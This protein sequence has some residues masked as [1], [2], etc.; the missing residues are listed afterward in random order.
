MKRSPL[1]VRTVSAGL[2]ISLAFLTGCPSPNGN[3]SGTDTSGADGGTSAPAEPSGR[4]ST[5]KAE[6]VEAAKTLLEGLAPGTKYTL[7]PDG[8]MTEVIIPD[9]SKLTPENIAL[10]G[11]L[12]DLEKLQIMNYRDL[13]DDMV[14]KLVDLKNLKTLALTNSVIGDP[15]VEM[16]VKS[17]P[18]LTSLDLSS[19]TN[20]TNGVLKVISEMGQLEQLTLVQNRFNDLG[21]GRLAKLEKL[22]SWTFVATWRRGT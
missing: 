21:T 4:T 16:I 11:R 12:S 1:L 19:N 3:D 17:F 18:N 20:M 7:V 15:A 8:V 22:R 5:A 2:I 13:D 10:F 6:D 14:A 9:G